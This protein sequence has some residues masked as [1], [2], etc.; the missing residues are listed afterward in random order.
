MV[1]FPTKAVGDLPT[2]LCSDIALMSSSESGP[3]MIGGINTYCPVVNKH[4]Y[5]KL[6]FIVDL[7]IKNGDFP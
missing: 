7:P 1:K 4:S 5:W 3:A 6:P 2:S